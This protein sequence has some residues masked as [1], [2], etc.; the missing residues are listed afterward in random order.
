MFKKSTKIQT[1]NEIKRKKIV[2]S[3]KKQKRLNES[4]A[5]Q[6]KN[7][8]QQGTVDDSAHTKRKSFKTD[9]KDWAS[10]TCMLIAKWKIKTTTNRQRT[11]T[12]R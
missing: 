4:K 9:E 1:V 6:S 5:K 7:N 11:V 8:Q 2:K 10:H 3:E 12:I